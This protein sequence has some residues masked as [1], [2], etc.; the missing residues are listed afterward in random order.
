MNGPIKAG[1]NFQTPLTMIHVPPGSIRSAVLASREGHVKLKKKG[2]NYL[3]SPHMVI[4]GAKK[5]DI[6]YM[7]FQNIRRASKRIGY[8]KREL[9]DEGKGTKSASYTTYESKSRLTSTLPCIFAV[10][11]RL[12]SFIFPPVALPSLLLK[13][14]ICGL[15]DSFCQLSFPAASQPDPYIVRQ[16]ISGWAYNLTGTKENNVGSSVY[17]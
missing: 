3:K 11:I 2:V 7:H 8:G 12:F 14:W 10:S 9:T 17:C 1:Q 16:L 15:L 6:N 4:T 13:G 5:V